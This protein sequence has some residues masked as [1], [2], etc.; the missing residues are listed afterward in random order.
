MDAVI[1]LKYF[2]EAMDSLDDFKFILK[3][4]LDIFFT[5]MNEVIMRDS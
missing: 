3:D 2:V 1:A 4:M 5:L